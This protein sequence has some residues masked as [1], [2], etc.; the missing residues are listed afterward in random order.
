M[1][2]KIVKPNVEKFIIRPDRNDEIYQK[3]M[4]ED[5]TLDYDSYSISGIGDCGNYS[6]KWSVTPEETFEHLCLRMLNS[7]EY[8]LEKF[9]SRSIFNLDE[10]KKLLLSY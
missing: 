8:L 3:C 5:I 7:S 10:S 6:Y 9:S 2:L 4:W 1:N